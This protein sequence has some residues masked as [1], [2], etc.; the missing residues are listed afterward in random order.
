[1]A[2]NLDR[3]EISSIEI[4]QIS[5]LDEYADES[6]EVNNLK[7]QIL[8]HSLAFRKNCA[9]FIDKCPE[10]SPRPFSGAVVLLFDINDKSSEFPFPI[11]ANIEKWVLDPSGFV[12]TE[13]LIDFQHSITLMQY[14]DFLL[15]KRNVL[16]FTSFLLFPEGD[17]LLDNVL[18]KVM[19][20]VK[21]QKIRLRIHV[22]GN[23]SVLVDPPLDKL[24]NTQRNTFLL[25]PPFENP[26]LVG[27][28]TRTT[29]KLVQ[30]NKESTI[31]DP[32]KVRLVKLTAPP[33]AMQ[34]Y[35]DYS[36]EMHDVSNKFAQAATVQTASN[37]LTSST[38][39][40]FLEGKNT[41][42]IDFKTKEHLTYTEEDITDFFTKTLTNSSKRKQ[43]QN[44]ELEF[45]EPQIENLLFEQEPDKIAQKAIKF[46]LGKYHFPPSKR[47]MTTLVIA[48]FLSF[49]RFDFGQSMATPPSYVR[50][51]LPNSN[52]IDSSFSSF[53]SLSSSSLPVTKPQ[54]ESIDGSLNVPYTPID[55]K[56]LEIPNVLVNEQGRLTAVPAT[57]VINDW[58]TKRYM[59]ISG[60]KSGHFVVFCDKSRELS[61]PALETFMQQFCHHYNE[62]NFGTLSEY[63]KCDPYHFATTSGLIDCID[64]F[65]KNENV[66][67]FQTIPILSFIFGQPIYNPTFSPR[68]IVTYVRTGIVASA[69]EEEI[70]SLAFVVY[71]RIRSM[72]SAPYGMWNL[73]T[74]ESATLFFGFRYT[75]TFVLPRDETTPT[76]VQI[77]YDPQTKLVAWMDS[78]GSVLQVQLIEN[79]SILVSRMRDLKELLNE[80]NLCFAITVLTDNLSQKLL[81]E[82]TSQMAEFTF[83]IYACYP[84]N[85]VQVKLPP[86]VVADVIHFSSPEQHMAKR[87]K[88]MTE[89]PATPLACCYVLNQNLPGYQ[90]L[91]Y[92]TI[93]KM[94]E[95][96]TH[97]FVNLMHKLSWLSVKPLCEKRTVAYPPHILALLRK[98]NACTDIVAP[99]E[100]LP[101]IEKI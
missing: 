30:I 93:T 39:F 42:L 41:N 69:D 96:S 6:Q 63:P 65:F 101:M 43:K 25:M 71:S 59:P 91:C 20:V 12:V 40:P 84:L 94:P 23:L 15:K 32:R 54:L 81:D 1:M 52:F 27:E 34:K 56:E 66:S 28:M 62:C 64:N 68:S 67:E 22:Q 37:K 90:M 13:A 99:Y 53:S 87:R 21:D 88:N 14:Y 72:Q 55:Y 76:Y 16:Y 35:F 10:Y 7:L 85:D 79:I 100:F 78:I 48:T 44:V 3:A 8:S 70:K 58:K 45:P 26:F 51:G 47:H 17:D 97:L 61:K 33:L 31:V 92:K 89:T 57:N 19:P 4:L 29:L 98:N 83:A 36:P 86:N 73:T 95:E 24:L 74:R 75:P 38:S 18:Y 2:W 60:K 9:I 80:P 11:W 50:V 5:I 82:L 77:G 49:F 46:G